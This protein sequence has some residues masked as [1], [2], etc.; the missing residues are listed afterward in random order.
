VSVYNFAARRWH[1]LFA[2]AALLAAAGIYVVKGLPMAIFPSV[3]FPIVKVIADAGEEPA[4]RM[5]P[6]VTRRLEEAMHRVPGVTLV[7]SITSRGSSELTAQ[8]AWGTNMETALQRVQMET[9]RV[10]PDLPPDTRIDVEWMNPASFP[11]LGYALTSKTRSQA[12]LLQMAEYTLKPELIRIPDVAQVQVQG[13]RR[14]E[15]EVHL[16]PAALQGRGLSVRDVVDAIQ[17]NHTVESAGLIERNHEL[18]LALVDGRV[19]D[20]DALGKLSVPVPDGPPATL[21]ELGHLRT[22]DEVSYVH[23]TADGDSAVLINLISQPAG[24][25]VAIADGVRQLFRDRPDLLPAGVTW[26]PFYDQARFVAASVHGT[27]DAILIGFALAAVVLLIGLRSL[28]LTVVAGL[29]IPFTVAIVGM[30]LGATGQTINLMTLAGV[31]ASI[32]LIADDAI[33]VVEHIEYQAARQAEG[34]AERG[35]RRLLPAL[36]GSSLST[37]I[38]LLPFALL[39]GIVGAFFKPLALTMALCLIFSFFLSWIVVPATVHRVGLPHRLP[40][41]PRPKENG[42]HRR[43]RAWSLAVGRGYDATVGALLRRPAIAILVTAGLIGVAWASYRH[44]GT[45]FLPSMDEGSIVLDY[46]TPP[47]TSLSETDAMLTDVERV[48]QALPDVAGY[49]RRTGTQLGFFITEPN[50]GDYVINLKPRGK[51]RPVDDVIDDLRARIAEVEPA[52]RTDFGQLIEDE[53]G[54]LTGGE[55]QPVDVK[56]FGDDIAVLQE[57]ARQ[58]ASFIEGIP[59]V[60]DVFNGITIAGPALTITPKPTAI[61]RYGLT[62][63][64]VHAAVEPAVIGTVADQIRV[65]DRLYDLRVFVKTDRP[66]ADLF[67]RSA[68]SPPALVPLSELASISTG[69]PE[70][71]IDR[72]NLRTYVGVTTRLSGRDLGSA[73]AEIRRTIKQKLTLAPGQYIRYGGLYAQQQKSFRDLLLVLLGGLALVSVV[74]LFQFGDWR[75]PLVTSLSAIAVLAGVFLAL[76]LTGMTLNISSYVGA[77]M[78]VGIVGENAIFVIHEGREGLR[79]GL[80]AHDAWLRA[81]RTRLRPVIMTVLATDLALAPLAVAFGE[82]SQLMQAL[83][84]AV[85]GGF[86]LSGVIVLLLLPALYCWLDPKGKLGTY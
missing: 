76:I 61:A 24:N 2:V 21:A 22:A 66:L 9:E 62:T 67:L 19:H 64:D 60:E 74:V 84:I 3:T 77:I 58:T 16:D 65:G 35:I 46:W 43:A 17:A 37:T 6:T 63:R 27:I 39:T 30:A 70:A 75:A 73:T 1:A 32:G 68:T 20:L 38:I 82:G 53:I 25:I 31:A 57:K 33:V 4:A 79:E 86:M 50:T 78:M 7:R 13:G 42:S 59:G 15:F 69:P 36:V 85:I 23:T 49:S 72:E 52:I 34:A 54:D 5:M 81:S 14:R 45:D 11:V 48:I 55:P 10:R 29:A 51:R 28:R 83:A 12:D 26:T 56:I 41:E 80:S 71:E 18:Y 44:V 8:F 40:Q 47:G